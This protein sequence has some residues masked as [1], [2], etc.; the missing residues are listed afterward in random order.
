MKIY[1]GGLVDNLSTL[2]PPDLKQLFSP[3]GDIVGVDLHKDPYTG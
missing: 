1:V 2:T 3:F